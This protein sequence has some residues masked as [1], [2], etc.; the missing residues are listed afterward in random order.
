MGIL[1]NLLNDYKIDRDFQ[2]EIRQEYRLDIQKALSNAFDGAKIQFRYGGSLA[3]G[4]AN[5]DSCDI[6]LLCYLSSE[7]NLTL[8]EIYDSAVKA[9]AEEGYWIERKNSAIKVYGRTNENMWDITVDV[10]PGKYSSN[11]NTDDVFL[12]R[13]ESNSK[14]KTNPIK[15]IEMVKQ[16]KSKEVIRIVKLFRDFNNFKFKSFFLENFVISI[17]EPEYEDGDNLFDK[18]IKFCDMYELI[19]VKK[20]NDPANSNND[21]MI[22]HNDFEFSTI[23]N[24]VKKLRDA[25]YTDD[26]ITIRKCIMGQNYDINEG[27]ISVAKG[28]S[29]LV[30]FPTSAI[31]PFGIISITGWFSKD[32]TFSNQ[33]YE[34]TELEYGLNLKFIAIVPNSIK[35]KSVSWLIC[36]SGYE[37]RVK[38]QLR[39]ENFESSDGSFGSG[40][41]N[42]FIK[43]EQTSFYGNHFVQ[44]RL[45]STTG[46]SYF[47]NIITIKIRK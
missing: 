21:I 5:I 36:N 46:K 31:V 34:S 38:D 41:S 17:V 44:A 6:D 35:I 33:I 20:V 24:Q 22:I 25:L 23:R 7:S 19:G 11:D 40:V 4:T 42:T 26:E 32:Q 9:L 1:N 39:G 13:N 30:K 12:W 16:S 18:L 37:A 28:H 47:S 27:Y 15:Q 10:V 43:Y 8:K 29:S 14:L 2:T 45:I 3:K